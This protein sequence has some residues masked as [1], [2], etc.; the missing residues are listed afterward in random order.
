VAPD[1]SAFAALL[2]ARDG[3]SP[4]GWY[5]SHT[6]DGLNLTPEDQALFNQFFP[7]EGEIALILKPSAGSEIET[8]TYIRGPAGSAAPPRNRSHARRWAA[9]AATLALLWIG[10]QALPGGLGLKI[11][12]VAPGQL[13]IEWDRG[14]GAVRW[15]SSGTL[16]ISDGASQVSLLLS[17]ERLRAGSIT[18]ARRTAEV[19]V[20]LHVDPQNVEEARRFSGAPVAVAEPPALEPPA[21]IPAS[22]RVERLEPDVVEPIVDRRPPVQAASPPTQKNSANVDRVSPPR[23][24]VVIPMP[25]APPAEPVSLPAPPLIAGNTPVAGNTLVAHLPSLGPL[26]QPRPYSGPR[27]GRLI[28]TGSLTRRGVVEIEGSHASIG[29]LIGGLP[30][31]PVTYGV[32]PAEF[33]AVGLVVYTGD[34]A[35]A[36]RRE[37][38]S[39]A[40]GWNATRFEWSPERAGQIAVLET[41]NASNEFRRLA[42]RSDARTCSVIVIEWGV[43]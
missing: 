33:S 14:S 7:R 38:A 5:S 16:E 21:V 23:R 42:V 34:S 35:K 32:S 20:K 1:E 31:V 8:A 43:E 25:A 4:V 28:W 27:S 17:G 37:P 10:V 15:A 2:P 12:G 11:Y 18:Y 29:S 36:G 26:A 3:L 6:R 9:V 40:N 22:E 41:P 13:R 24:L 30:G 19:F 39:R